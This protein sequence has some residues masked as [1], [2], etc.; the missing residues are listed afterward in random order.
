M[1]WCRAIFR[2]PSGASAHI[3]SQYRWLAPPANIRCPSGDK[4][5]WLQED[6]AASGDILPLRT[7]EASRNLPV[8]KASEI[9]GWLACASG[10]GHKPVATTCQR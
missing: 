6:Q 5:C 1:E 7:A 2:R 4:S 10:T 8:A 9:T 3:G